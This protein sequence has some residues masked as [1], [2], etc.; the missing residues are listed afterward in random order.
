MGPGIFGPHRGQPL[1]V[2][3]VS[4]TTITALSPNAQTV[5]VTVASTTTYD[6]GGSSKALS[7]IQVGSLI[8]VRGSNANATAITA[9]A[10]EIVLPQ[11]HGVVTA[12]NGATLTLTSLDA[13]TQIIHADGAT[14]KQA[15]QSATAADVQVGS[16]IS[17]QGTRNTDGS[18]QATSIQIQLP[19]LGGAV[20]SVS[21]NGTGSTITVSGAY[22]DTYTINT[23][24]STTFTQIGFDQTTGKPSSNTV[25]AAAVKTGA[26]IQAE[27]ALSADGK[28]L[29]AL[30]VVVLPNAGQFGGRHRLGRAGGNGAGP[31]FGNVQGMFGMGGFQAPAGNGDAATSSTS[32]F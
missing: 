20:K 1:K 24:S 18:L 15:G 11:V 3:A 7:D 5:T 32:S 28:T 13:T 26:A 4:G 31:S 21:P 19:H 23:S 12:V 29:N 10:V 22:G 25:T 30:T 6:E 9:T 17:A 14:Y 2:T 16:L 8:V 27:G